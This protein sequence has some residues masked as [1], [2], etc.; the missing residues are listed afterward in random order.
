MHKTLTSALALAG[1]AAAAGVAQAADVV[2]AGDTDE[3][4]LLTST[5][6]DTV[7]AS[8]KA[9]ASVYAS[10]DVDVFFSGELFVFPY[11][12]SAA[13]RADIFPYGPSFVN[14]NTFA[15]SDP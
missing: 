12:A 15:S 4:M 13:I 9:S 14:M 7:T 11:S 6:M 8:G 10:G 2:V 3:P 5:Q 1:L